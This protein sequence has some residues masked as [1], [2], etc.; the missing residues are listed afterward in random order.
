MIN[1]PHKTVCNGNTQY[2]AVGP[3]ISARGSNS[4]NAANGAMNA[5]NEEKALDIKAGI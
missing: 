3:M 2:F 4:R 5:F 1:A